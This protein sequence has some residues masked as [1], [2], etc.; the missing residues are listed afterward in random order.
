MGFSTGLVG[1]NLVALVILPP[2]SSQGDLH[3]YPS[4]VAKVNAGRNDGEPLFLSLSIDRVDLFSVKQQFSVAPALRLEVMGVG[5]RLDVQIHDPELSV[6][7]AA[8]GIGHVD[9]A[10]EDALDFGALQGDA[11]L[12][13]I[14]QL[15]VVPRLPVHDRSW[16]FQ[17]LGGSFLAHGSGSLLKGVEPVWVHF[18]MM[19]SRF[20]IAALAGVL[21]GC[22]AP[23]KEAP[24]PVA[25][26]APAQNNH[27]G[28]RAP[29]KALATR[30]LVVGNGVV[31]GVKIAGNPT[32]KAGDSVTVFYTGKLG[33]GTVF[34]SN[35][36]SKGKDPDPFIFTVGQPDLIAGWSQGMIGMKVGGTREID[37]PSSLGYG[38]R[39]GGP[40]PPNADLFFTIKVLDVVKA[41]E[42]GIF[43]ITD[44]KQGSGPVVKDGSQVSLRYTGKLTSGRLFDTNEDDPKKPL[45]TFT[46]GKG[47]VI[48][49][50]EAGVK[51]MRQGGVRLIRVP[52]Q[53]GYMTKN[54]PGIPPNSTLI[55]KVSVINVK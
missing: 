54:V 17:R 44:A 25:A 9:P 42:E 53:I 7:N 11:R 6:E 41:G 15:V 47:M 32:I 49:G 38:P 13:R 29:L 23:P 19:K 46:V 26:T 35:F 24:K 22:N 27:S 21:I 14:E 10:E 40:I 3:L 52:P 18:H 51:G 50:F 33:D 43:D 34:D 36:P 4:L 39:G 2:P 48:P 5:V 16:P 1:L 28:K 31:Q 55:F 20:C 45:L 8:E 37:I 30:D 12:V